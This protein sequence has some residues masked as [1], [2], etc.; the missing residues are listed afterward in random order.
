[1]EHTT[2]EVVEQ[3]ILSKVHEKR[4]TMTGEKPICNGELFQDFGYTGNTPASTAVLGLRWYLHG[5][6]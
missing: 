6:T 2:Q 5:T 1:V 3:A 4:Y